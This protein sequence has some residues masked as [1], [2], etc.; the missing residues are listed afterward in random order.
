MEKYIVIRSRQVKCLTNIVLCSI[1][2]TAILL[3]INLSLSVPFHLLVILFL[4]LILFVTWSYHPRYLLLTDDALIVKRGWG[5][6]SIPYSQIKTVQSYRMTSKDIRLWGS[7]G[8][9]GYF[10]LFY[11]RSLGRYY[12]YAGDLDETFLLTTHNGRSYLLSASHSQEVM[13]KL[14]LQIADHL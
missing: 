10:G 14:K 7:G 1:V 2:A 9:W 3:T 11:N 8:M 4:L 12:A 6:L 5:Q 13:D